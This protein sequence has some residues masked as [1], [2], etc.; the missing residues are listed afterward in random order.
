MIYSDFLKYQT[1]AILHLYG[2][3]FLLGVVFFIE[4]LFKFVSSEESSFAWNNG[5]RGKKIKL[6]PERY[7]LID[8]AKQGALLSSHELS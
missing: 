8:L 1:R 6:Q 3:P 4:F 5:V 2:K 7:G